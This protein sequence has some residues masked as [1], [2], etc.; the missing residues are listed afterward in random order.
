MLRT[1]I[2]TY[3]PETDREAIKEATRLA[4]AKSDGELVCFIVERCDPYEEVWWKSAAFVG[5][6]AA[7]CTAIVVQLRLGWGARGHIGVL[8]ALGAGGL[9]GLLIAT[10]WPA[11]R[12]RLIGLETLERRANAR[13]VE[14]F[15]EE[16]VFAT[17]AR[18]GILIFLG[19]FE[20]E[21]VIL[22]DQGIHHA[23]PAGTWKRIADDVA[24]TIRDGKPKDALLHA[25]EECGTLLETYAGPPQQKDENELSDAP[26]FRN[27]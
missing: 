25:I 5:V 15:L 23:A 27:E 17:H 26:R 2:D 14:A 3:F 11:L 1:L 24:K 18:N 16:G 8:F 22:A 7:L 4:E 9:L 12:R 19:L 10:V 21:V 20:H 6:L 13:A